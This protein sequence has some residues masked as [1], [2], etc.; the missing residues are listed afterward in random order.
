MGVAMIVAAAVIGTAGGKFTAV[1]SLLCAAR[2]PAAMIVLVMDITAASARH[3]G[4]VAG[5]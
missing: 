4:P 3:G 2:L 1:R 5:S